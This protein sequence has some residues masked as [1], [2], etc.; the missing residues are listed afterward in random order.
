MNG[1]APSQ[2][3]RR[4][5]HVA[6][7]LTLGLAFVGFLRGVRETGHHAANP[8]P[9]LAASYA[10]APGYAELRA[11]Q[12]GPNARLY[13]G[14]FPALSRGLPGPGASV[15][16]PPEARS[17]AVAARAARRAYD[18]AP[19]T[20]P[21][22]VDQQR[23][24][25]CLACH[26]SGA[27]VAGEVARRMSHARHDNC[28]QCHVVRADPRPGAPS[29]PAPDNGFVGLTS[30]LRGARA[31]DGAP[32]TIPHSTWM[33]EQCASCHGPAGAPGLRST[34]PHR[35]SCTQCHTP[36]AGLDQ[37]ELAGTAGPA[38]WSPVP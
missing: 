15:E 30:P 9:T 1:G 12:R 27:V 3:P 22:D 20:I 35:Q 36:S 17:A 32:P 10:P 16:Q 28:L 37:R 18:G 11:V 24:P 4:L 21:H 26:E 6:A 29:V 31:Y 23:A 8:P 38:G 19:P 25:A 34:H 14:A 33:R 13:D 2:A 7:A 5:A